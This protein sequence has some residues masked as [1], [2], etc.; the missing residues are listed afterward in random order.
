MDAVFWILQV[1]FAV[2]PLGL[3]KGG[4][5]K[6]CEDENFNWKKNKRGVFMLI[7]KGSPATRLSQTVGC[8]A[9]NF[10]LMEK[11][12]TIFP[13]EPVVLHQSYIL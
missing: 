2:H 3:H 1:G 12:A 9:K 7:S 11:I 6:F 10:A 4:C 8:T 13:L 5:V